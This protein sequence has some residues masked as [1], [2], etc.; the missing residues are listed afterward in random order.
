MQ[1][2]CHTSLP[3]VAAARSDAARRGRRRTSRRRRL[4]LP[5]ER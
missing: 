1:I 4:P 2:T 3:Q 5:A